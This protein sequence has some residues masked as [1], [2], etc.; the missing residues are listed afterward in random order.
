MNKRNTMRILRI[1]DENPTVKTFFFAAKTE[2]KPGQFIMLTDLENGE[3]PFSISIC[4]ADYFGVTIKKVG[5]FTESLFS[6][7]AGDLLSWRGPY[8]S[9]FELKGKR[10]LL[11]GGGYAA[12]TLYFLGKEL[13]KTGARV[14]VVNGA[15]VKEDLV[16][17]E[18]FRELELTYKNI[19]D[20][21]CMGAKGT[22][23]DLAKELLSGSVFDMVYVSGPELM[24]KAMKQ[25]LSEYKELDYEFLFE[26]YMKCAI[27]LC[28]NCTIDPLGIRLCVEGPVLGRD[29]VEQLTEFGNYHRD[30]AGTKHYYGEK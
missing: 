30:A 10:C 26:R 14:T 19:T 16:F 5:K 2:A 13:L 3:K 22:S 4:E 20:A 27:G 11:V 21:G 7:K 25:L 28:G 6:K 24:M 29:K 18:R 9:S 15:R 1:E 8:G 12:P 23:V 17:C